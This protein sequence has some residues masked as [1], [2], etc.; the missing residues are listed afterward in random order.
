LKDNKVLAVLD[1]D[2]K[3]YGEFDAVD[4]KHLECIAKEIVNF[5]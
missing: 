1:I 2:S 5:L 3:N 4:K